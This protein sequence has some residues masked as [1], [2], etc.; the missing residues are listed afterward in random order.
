MFQ[1]L[2]Y[3]KDWRN[4]ADF[5]TVETD[6]SQVREDMQILFDEARNALNAL[7]DALSARTAAG[8]I[9]AEMN[10]AQTSV[11]SVLT[12]L[13]GDK[14]RHEDLTALE[15]LVL[16]FAGMTLTNELTAD[17][18]K[19][20]TSKAV[21]E[22]MRTASTGML[23]QVYDPQGLKRDIFAFAADLLLAHA[24]LKSNPHTVT[25]A[26]VGLGKVDNTPDAEK[27][28][29]EATATALRGKVGTGD[30]I[31]LQ[32]GGTGATTVAQARK[33]LGL[34][35]S[36]GAIP[37]TSGGTG[38]TTAA[39]ARTN[40]GITP[41]NIGALAAT[42][43]AAASKMLGAAEWVSGSILTFAENCKEGV[44][45]F[46]T[47]ASTTDLPNSYYGYSMGFVY[48]RSA[49]FILIEVNPYVGNMGR[50]RRAYNGSWSDWHFDLS[51][52]LPDDM[53]GDEFPADATKGRLFFK[54]VSS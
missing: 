39:L 35:D 36:A 38:A 12:A 52:I 40:L 13:L 33:N 50:A 10:G 22:G 14:H 27:P 45:P 4:P 6:E 19:I 46:I 21:I 24:D 31:D 29:S 25:A 32:H 11:Q 20:P 42:G 44:T 23:P 30:V 1:K 49:N 18:T 43:T 17:A 8:E 15:A 53:Y 2:N 34:G 28:I 48:K 7:I 26:Q 54:K 3:T 51:T 47:Q 5:P 9:G 16:A 37:I 41:A